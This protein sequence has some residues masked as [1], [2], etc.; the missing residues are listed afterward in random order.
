MMGKKKI[1]KKKGRSLA[2]FHTKKELEV[3]YRKTITYSLKPQIHLL[4][5]HTPISSL[6]PIADT[7]RSTQPSPPSTVRKMP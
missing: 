6:K 3:L 7:D 1:R 5:Q 2:W 4:T